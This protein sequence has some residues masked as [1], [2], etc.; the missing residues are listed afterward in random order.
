MMNSAQTSHLT[1]AATQGLTPLPDWG[2]IM[3][4]GPDA[5]SL[6]QGQLSN[7]VLG[8]EPCF[9]GQIAQSNDVRLV[10]YCNPKGRLLASAWLS[11]FPQSTE[12][13][14][15][16]V[17]FI[18]RD[19]AASIAKRLSMYV[20]RSKVKI[21]D[22]SD[23][24]V[25]LGSY[26]SS[27]IDSAPE[28]PKDGFALQLP[29]VVVAQTSYRRTLIACPK[30]NS[31]DIDID[32][33]CLGYWNT[34]EIQSAIPRIVLATQE[35]FV[36]QMIN[37]ESVA[38]VDFKKGC[39]PGQEI[40]A[41]S[42]YRGVI[43]RRLQLASTANTPQTSNIVKPACELFYSGDSTQPCGMV[44]LAAQDAFDPKRIS[45]QVE[46]KLDALDDGDIYLGNSSGP[47]LNIE[48][49]PYPLIEI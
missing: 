20:L 7:S 13:D 40:V 25:V 17:L 41:R 43:K 11:L 22:A 31:I 12:S 35:Q 9:T 10:G 1:D 19:I 48:P 39:Y 29:P 16:F 45:L 37:F 42:Q 32:L 5:A 34:L 4:E 27:Q 30:K 14:D 26:A 28:I 24:W 15:R 47:R 23:E 8:L 46:C 38:G 33:Q 44:V 21:L 49:L 36:P 2:L 3:V 18:S 6:L